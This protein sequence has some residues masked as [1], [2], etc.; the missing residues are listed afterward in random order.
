MKVDLNKIKKLPPDVRDKFYKIYLLNEKKKKESKMRSDFLSFVKHIWP[1]FVEGRHH[2]IIAQ[3]FND[4]ASGKIKRLI[5]NMPPRHTKSEFASYIL[6]AW[7]VG[8]N[9][10]LKIIQTT[11]TAELAVRF[12]RK[13]KSLL[14][15]AEYQQIFT[16]RLRED[17]QA[18]GHKAVN[19][20]QRVSVVRSR[21]VVRIS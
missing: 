16:T 21:A 14:D 6:P 17:S 13:A 9:P 20:L 8:R 11:H 4:L 12:G 7:M 1:D 19:I 10:K 5:V 15:S 2:K 18:A 3:K